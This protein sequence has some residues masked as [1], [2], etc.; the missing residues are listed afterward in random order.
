MKTAR[1][2]G[3]LREVKDG[4]WLW[5]IIDGLCSRCRAAESYAAC[6]KRVK[7]LKEGKP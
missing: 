4:S 1:C 7:A 2:A 6:E 5:P 3:C